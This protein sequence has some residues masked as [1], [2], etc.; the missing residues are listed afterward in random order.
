MKSL[1]GGAF[2]IVPILILIL[3]GWHIYAQ[4]KADP[5]P[6]QAG[7]GTRVFGE[8]FDCSDIL[9][10]LDADQDGYITRDEWERF[11]DN[12]DSD[13][14]SRLSP[15]EVQPISH[16]SRTEEAL[17]PDQ[18]RLAAFE[19]L[20]V[21]KNDVIGLPEWPGKEKN[22]RFLD[23]NHDGFLSREEFLSRN[24]RWWNEKFEHLD[25]NDD[26]II[27]RSE[28]LDSDS[29]FDRLDRDRNGV[30]ERHEFYTRR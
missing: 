19:R 18:G 17:R 27:I 12:S 16:R 28:W 25:F 23:A 14:D 13:A 24:G 11:F 9:K 3:A 26:G 22:F 29:T 20:D 10:R 2:R 8:A 7:I 5:Q 21:N 30:I 6:F 4:S 15:E 1:G